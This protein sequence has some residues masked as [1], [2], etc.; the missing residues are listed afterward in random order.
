VGSSN[1]THVWSA[2]GDVTLQKTTLAN[3]YFQILNH[4]RIVSSLK[5]KIKLEA[6]KIHLCSKPFCN[7]NYTVKQLKLKGSISEVGNFTMQDSVYSQWCRSFSLASQFMPL[8]SWPITHL[9]IS[10]EAFLPKS[11]L[12]F[13]FNFNTCFTYSVLWMWSLQ[14]YLTYSILSL[15]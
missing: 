5:N 10:L 9:S 1:Y 4:I 13:G 15:I 3:S 2:S 11:L 14:L 6:S 7:K 8:V 12:P